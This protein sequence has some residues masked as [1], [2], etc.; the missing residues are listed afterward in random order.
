MSALADALVAA[1]RRALTA[2][3][4]SYLAGGQDDDS[5]ADAMERIGATDV[6]D[7]ER[8]IA[9]LSVIRELGASLPS[10]P[11]NGAQKPKEGVTQAQSDYIDKLWTQRGGKPGDKPILTGITKEDASRLI[12]QLKTDTYNVSDWEIPF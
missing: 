1:Q 5:M 9:S 3:E 2:L 8:L 10:E 7:R 11:T 6:V 12:E 4:K